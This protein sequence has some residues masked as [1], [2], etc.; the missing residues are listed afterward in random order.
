MSSRAVNMSEFVSYFPEPE[1]G[2]FRLI[3]CSVSV[4]P[5]SDELIQ[6]ILDQAHPYNDEHDITGLLIADHKLF[7]QMLEGPVKEVKAL[8]AKISQD[9]RHQCVVQLMRQPNITQRQY[10]NWGMAWGRV[11]REEIRAIVEEAKAHLETGQFTPWAPAVSLLSVLLDAE[12][13]HEY[14][15]ALTGPTPLPQRKLA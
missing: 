10:P 1:E 9:P 5:I 11:T 8:F 4:D 2:L 6:S 3:Y 13:G 14:A 7:V 12:F 15:Q